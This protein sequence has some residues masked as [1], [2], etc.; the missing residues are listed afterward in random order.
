MS[1]THQIKPRTSYIYPL[2]GHDNE[3]RDQR[4][5]L[6]PYATSAIRVITYKMNLN[7]QD[8]IKWISY[9]SE[10][11]VLPN[12]SFVFTYMVHH[13][14]TIHPFIEAIVHIHQ[15]HF[16]SDILKML[17]MDFFLVNYIEFIF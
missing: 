4:T 2:F 6:S 3:D 15:W 12:P 17:Y 14:Q 7:V 16:P 10:W 8:P 9:T 1:K 11:T 5:L 13:I